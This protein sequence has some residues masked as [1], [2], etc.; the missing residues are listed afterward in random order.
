MWCCFRP[1]V[2]SK[3]K[4]A[5]ALL[6]AELVRSK[7]KIARCIVVLA[8]Q[9]IA[10]ANVPK[11]RLGPQHRCSGSL[12]SRGAVFLKKPLMVSAQARTAFE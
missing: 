6:Y 12:I 5:L 11:T 4:T 7:V 8:N 10:M 3:S 9:L 2:E 1:A